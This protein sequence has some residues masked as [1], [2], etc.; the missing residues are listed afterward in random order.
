MP[1]LAVLEIFETSRKD[2]LDV[3]RFDGMQDM[4]SEQCRMC[5]RPRAFLLVMSKDEIVK[6]IT[7]ETKDLDD[8]IYPP[9]KLVDGQMWR[10]TA[11]VK[12][13][14]LE[15]TLCQISS[16]PSLK[17]IDKWEEKHCL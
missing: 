3:S 2:S 17:K 11:I 5:V 4:L 13:K 6:H 12:S 14:S 8:S 16:K 15:T 7:F 10:L 1:Y 9:G